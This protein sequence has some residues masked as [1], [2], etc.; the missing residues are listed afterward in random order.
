MSKNQTEVRWIVKY[1]PQKMEDREIK[2][3]FSEKDA[4]VLFKK[5]EKMNF[6][7]DVLKETST[8]TATTT[9][10]LTPE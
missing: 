3:T 2:Y 9:E 8:T 4:L 10:T 7:V 1:G 5:Y 6:H